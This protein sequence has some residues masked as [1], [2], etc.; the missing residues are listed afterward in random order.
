MKGIRLPRRGGFRAPAVD[1]CDRSLERVDDADVEAGRPTEADPIIGWMLER[2]AGT[3][4]RPRSRLAYTHED[5]RGGAR[6]AGFLG[7]RSEP[8][9]RFVSQRFGM[10]IWW[11]DKSGEAGKF[12]RGVRHPSDTYLTPID[13]GLSG[14]TGSREN[15]ANTA[16]APARALA[17][18]VARVF[19]SFPA[20]CPLG[21][22]GSTAT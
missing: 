3:V 17:I 16:C 1:G 22:I 11:M 12:C 4:E 15:A 7:Q 5:L 10:N 20:T 6:R 2:H 13:S 8:A 19:S 21:A 9:P 14:G 18:N